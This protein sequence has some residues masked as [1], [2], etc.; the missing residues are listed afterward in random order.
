M[1]AG[2]PGETDAEFE[3]TFAFCRDMD[4]AW[5]HAF[6]FSARPGTAAFD[7]RPKV[8]ERVAGERV[9]RLA[10]L[11]RAGKARYVARWV[12]KTVDVVLEKGGALDADDEV[13]IAD[14]GRGAL[15]PT[16]AGT[17]SNYLKLRIEGLPESSLPGRL[18][19]AVIGEPCGA[20]SFDA[21]ALFG[22]F[23]PRMD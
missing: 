18:V 10:E 9:A 2:F 12:G 13:S 15:V 8:P 23:P 20:G 6:P 3:E 21:L 16:Q 4:F 5:I 22:G 14:G 19:R 17:S 11:A 7:M 1:I